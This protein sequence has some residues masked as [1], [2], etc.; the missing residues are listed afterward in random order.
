MAGPQHHFIVVEQFIHRFLSQWN[1]GLQP[2]LKLHSEPS[3]AITID[4]KVTTSVPSAEVDHLK[5][6]DLGK[7]EKIIGV[8]FKE[9]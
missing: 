6:E 9:I 5:S 8:L 1:I 2:S 7:E 3:G 4:Y